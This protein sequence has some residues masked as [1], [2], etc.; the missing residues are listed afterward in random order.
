MIFQPLIS[1]GSD[2]PGR[3]SWTAPVQ[4]QPKL[5]QAK[6][7]NKLDEGGNSAWLP[8]DLTQQAESEQMHAPCAG[9]PLAT[10]AIQEAIILTVTMACVCTET[11]S[12]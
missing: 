3:T 7:Q 5:K 1:G 2:W 10:L 8:W 6:L 12:L 11:D 4:C 9:N